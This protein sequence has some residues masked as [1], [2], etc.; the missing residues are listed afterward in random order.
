VT[1]QE[2]Q[3][4]QRDGAENPIARALQRIMGTPWF[5]TDEKYAGGTLVYELVPPYHV[6]VLDPETYNNWKQYR[7]SGL[8]WP[9]EFAITFEDQL[10][11]R[12]T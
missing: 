6:A 10:K 7:S 5:L 3:G 12:D 2:I 1:S 9:F 8:M 4:A 11:H